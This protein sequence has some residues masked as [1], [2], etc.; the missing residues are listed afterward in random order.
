MA[1]EG[2]P[3]AAGP[4]MWIGA[5]LLAQ[6]GWGIYPALGRYM[7]TVSGL[8]SMSILVIGGMPMVLL[9]LIYVLPKYG[10]SIFQSRTIWMLALVVAARS[11]TN[12]LAMRF[13]MAIY[14][15]LITLMTPFLVVALSLLL[16]QEAVPPYT[17]RAVSLTFVG[18][19]LMLSSEIGS[20][21]IRFDLALGDW[22]GISLALASSFMLALYMLLIR[23]TAKLVVP[24]QVILIFQITV[25][26]AVSL[27]ISLLLSEDRSRW[28]EI[29]ATDWLVVIAYIFV[30]MI[31]A[32]GL[33]IASLRQLGA[34]FV[35]S[36][37]AWRLVSALLFAGLLLG[38][39][40]TSPAQMLGVAIV[41]VTITW[42]LWQQREQ[43]KERSK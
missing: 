4:W 5:A 36:L 37:M 16:V 29:G 11:T 38:E 12:L 22:I 21:G 20:T 2:R 10:V 43:R 26:V 9:M 42:Y 1:N 6:T 31:G 23:R 34:P 40:L 27:P 13:T 41:M 39:W 25:V 17:G 14:V 28:A 19:V 7:Q 32:N 8:P 18:A 15:Q 30:V 24:G 3:S 35:S 33:Q